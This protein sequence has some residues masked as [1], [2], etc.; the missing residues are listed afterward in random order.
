M[1]VREIAMA[2]TFTRYGLFAELLPAVVL[3][4]LEERVDVLVLGGDGLVEPRQHVAHVAKRVVRMKLDGARGAAC[5]EVKVAK[6]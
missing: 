4:E 6:K 1:I 2:S 5:K 3:A